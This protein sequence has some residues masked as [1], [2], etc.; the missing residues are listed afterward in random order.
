MKLRLNNH[1]KVSLH[2]LYSDRRNAIIDLIYGEKKFYKIEPLRFD[3]G[4][5]INEC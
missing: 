3:A 2:C 5:L 1:A 4:I